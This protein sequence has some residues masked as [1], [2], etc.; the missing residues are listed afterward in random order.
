MTLESASTI[1]IQT[2]RVT[3][4][5]T[6]LPNPREA[7]GQTLQIR[8]WTQADDT[9]AE[10]I[11]GTYVTESSMPDPPCVASY[12]CLVVCSLNPT[13]IKKGLPSTTIGGCRASQKGFQGGYLCQTLRTM[14]KRGITYQSGAYLGFDPVDVDLD[15]SARQPSY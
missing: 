13:D 7:W 10:M 2:L 3:L 8:Q 1:G 9:R 11:L 14:P 6:R 15:A 5:D 4:L 12:Y